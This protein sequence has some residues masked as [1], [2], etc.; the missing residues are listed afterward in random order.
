MFMFRT[1]RIVPDHQFCN[2][3]ISNVLCKDRK[4]WEIGLIDGT[5]FKLEDIFG[6][7]TLFFLLYSIF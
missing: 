3:L 7:I 5:K 6:M 2:D 4:E 1:H